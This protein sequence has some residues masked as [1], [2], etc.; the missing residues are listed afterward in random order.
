M[1]TT[2][3]IIEFDET[4]EPISN[5]MMVRMAQLLQS[6]DL[7]IT[8]HLAGETYPEPSYGRFEA[9]QR[10]FTKFQEQK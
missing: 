3:K 2:E 8:D 10:A 9:W 4:H 7:I 5:K 1:K 6:I